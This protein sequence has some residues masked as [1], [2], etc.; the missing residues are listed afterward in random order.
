MLAYVTH[1]I[2]GEHKE[3]D[4]TIKDTVITVKVVN[5]DTWFKCELG[6]DIS[7]A[8]SFIMKPGWILGLNKFRVID[9]NIPIKQ[10]WFIQQRDF[11]KKGLKQYMESSPLMKSSG[12]T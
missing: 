7:K 6:P 12:G 8:L 3:S 10:S 5:T 1:D 9:A 11:V 4:V 2:I